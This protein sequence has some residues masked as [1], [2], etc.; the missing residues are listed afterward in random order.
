MKDSAAYLVE[1]REY[2]IGE[3]S[4]RPEASPIPNHA[5]PY[6]DNAVLTTRSQPDKKIELSGD[7]DAYKLFFQAI[8]NGGK[9]VWGSTEE[10]RISY[11]NTPPNATS[12]QK[13]IVVSSFARP[14][15]TKTK[16]LLL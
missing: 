14:I 15:P 11:L 13:A 1:G 12:P 16:S 9:S 4:L 5:I 8:P 10:S 6:S 3:L 7:T 2:V